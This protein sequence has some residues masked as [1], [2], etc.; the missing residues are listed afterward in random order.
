MQA[1]KFRKLCEI[2]MPTFSA[3]IQELDLLKTYNSI[4][5][6]TLVYR[7]NTFT[8]LLDKHALVQNKSVLVKNKGY[9]Y[10]S[11]WTTTLYGQLKMDCEKHKKAFRKKGLR[12]DRHMYK[13][14]R[15]V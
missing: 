8:R 15:D 13:S 2:D 9:C 5:L 1:F 10:C 7:Y 6:P 3:D 12:N 4:D 11:K 14:Q